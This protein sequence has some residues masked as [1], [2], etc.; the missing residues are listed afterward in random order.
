M[1]TEA[2]LQR[3]KE[4]Q[5]AEELLF[6]GPQALGFAKGLFAGHFVSD[7]VMPYPKISAAQQTQLDGI[8]S[9]LRAFLDAELDA[10]EID[11]Q[12]DIPRKV[13]DGLGRVGV[14]GMTAPAEYGGHG[15][16]QLAN[17][18]ILE[19]IGTRCASTS[20]FVNAHHSIGIRAL[21]LFGT[22]EQKQKWLPKLCTG[23]W[24]GA[25]A[26]T[27]RE[28]GSD[29][30]N[31]QMTAT[32]SEDGSHY[33][34]NGEKRYITNA[35]IAQVLTVMARTPVPGKPGK[36]AITAFLVTPDMPGFEMLEARMAK[37][38]IR[39]TATGRFACRDMKVPKE[40]I[41]GPLGKGLK[42]ALTVLDFGR[43][44]FGA[45]CTGA[46]KTCLDLAVKHATTRKQF[47][48]T[49]GSFHLVKKK[50]ARIAADAYAM[51]AMTSITAALI[52]RGLEDYMLET[53]MLKVFTTER[54][55]ECINDAFQI[56][57]GSAYFVDLP[58]ERM[59]RDARI[60]QIGEGSNE[61]LTSFVALV[62]MRGPGMEFKE[63]YDTM[64]KPTR[65][66][67][68]GKAWNAGLSR[69]GATVRTPDVPVRSAELKSFGNQL[70]RLIWRFNFAVNKSLVLF[71]EP[72]LDMQ[73]V[74]ER[75]ANAATEL[76]ASTCALS[77]WDAEIQSSQRNGQSP[78]QK[79]SAAE[80][81]LR[82]SFRRI[83]NNLAGLG[84][85]EDEFI[86][87][88]ADA[89]LG[90]SGSAAAASPV[91]GGPL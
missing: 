1:A 73:L 32:P 16:S 90:N 49:L 17:T 47:N 82:Q 37:T 78:T 48:K 56:Y 63:I 69:L 68:I 55:W 62:G 38:G 66:G 30:A 74:Q 46:A 22:H 33:I 84:D 36:D 89:A 42:V 10:A 19:E 53:A 57:G 6:T 12:A 72:I 81:F 77:R 14:L 26:L 41:L 79:N 59:L 27:E 83:R 23:E 70:G 39:G 15:F 50:I 3:Q 60:N 4:M 65:E 35:A 85:N 67:G 11:R 87:K 54:L 91:A 44:T 71:R 76:F 21:L 43:T 86:L 13:I 24:L 45:C 2:E 88:A 20:V 75:I 31:V 7:W 8:L 9:E 58:L 34:L 52:D 61:V 28:A 5:Q 40:N 80:L 18:K 64:L 51:E 29:A 25:F